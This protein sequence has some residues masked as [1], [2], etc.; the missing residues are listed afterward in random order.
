MNW[1]SLFAIGFLLLALF[2]SA[3]LALAL[4]AVPVAGLAIGLNWLISPRR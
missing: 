2:P 4:A 1:L 3:W